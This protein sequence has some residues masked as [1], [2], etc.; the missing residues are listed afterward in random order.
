MNILRVKRTSLTN[1]KR[2]EINLKLHTNIYL[3]DPAW[4]YS[5]I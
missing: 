3:T 4:Q 5:I 1:H 2:S